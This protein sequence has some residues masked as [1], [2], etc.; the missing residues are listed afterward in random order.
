MG[1]VWVLQAWGAALKTRGPR[2][3]AAHAG[4]ASAVRKAFQTCMCYLSPVCYLEQGR[5]AGDHALARKAL[6][7]GRFR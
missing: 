1:R 2:A 3:A 7:D 6:A 4:V 5:E